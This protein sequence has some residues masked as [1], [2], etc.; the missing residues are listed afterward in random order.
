[1]ISIAVTS[2]ESRFFPVILSLLDHIL[3]RVRKMN[4]DFYR[5]HC[6]EY[7]NRY[8]KIFKYF[9]GRPKLKTVL[10]TVSKLFTAAVYFAYVFLLISTAV[11]YGLSEKLIRVT[12]VPA[13]AFAIVTVI[14]KKINAPRPYEKYPVTPLVKKS[15]K[16]NSCPSRHSACAFIIALACLYADPVFGVVMTVIAAAVAAFRPVSG[17]HFP[18]DVVFGMLLSL[19][20]GVIGFWII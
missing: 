3:E 5:K 7:F 19:I 16:G 9:T 1:M 8:I 14:R 6:D 17:V 20:I 13:A 11:T 18:Y 15:T 4:Y 10:V 12:A 2:A